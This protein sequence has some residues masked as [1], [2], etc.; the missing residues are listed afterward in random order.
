MTQDFKK[1]LD[2]FRIRM[3]KLGSRRDIWSVNEFT[4]E[5]T[6]Y[7]EIL[8]QQECFW[9]Q[10][11]KQYWLR[12]ADSNT[13]FFHLFASSRKKTNKIVS[14]RDASGHGESEVEQVH[15]IICQ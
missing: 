7:H 10:R 8:E 14:L 2:G 15:S 3:K 9:K 1:R 11:A 13:R 6:E 12:D 4:R 5:R